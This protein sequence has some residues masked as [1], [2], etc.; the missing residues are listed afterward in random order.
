MDDASLIA[1]ISEMVFF[2]I[3]TLI[4]IFVLSYKNYKNSNYYKITLNPFWYVFLD[5]GSYGEYKIYQHLQP[6]ELLGCK[7]LFNL[8]IPK[9]NGKTSEID[10]IMFHQKGLFVIESKN[11][12]GWIF[13][14]E[15]N[16]Q[17]TQIFPAGRGRSHK[18][19]FYNPIMQNL[20]HIRALRKNIDA[21]IP[22]YSVI[23]FSDKCTLKDVTV[24]SNVIVTYYSCLLDNMKIKLSEINNYSMSEELLNK[25]YNKLI[26]YTNVDNNTKLQH[27]YNIR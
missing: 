10:A 8:Y 24:N 26:K 4:I 21:T 16:K 7:F 11:Y 14:N 18:E 5:S 22:I 2:V 12:G 17:W 19:Y 1:L 25:T 13:G 27:I 3:L 9:D 6:L 20:T 15:R 23:A